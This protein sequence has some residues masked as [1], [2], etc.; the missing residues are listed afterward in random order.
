MCRPIYWQV[1]ASGLS[2]L[3]ELSPF[4]QTWADKETENNRT[5][6]PKLHL[7]GWSREPEV[8]S[9]LLSLVRSSILSRVSL[10][11]SCDFGSFGDGARLQD[12][13]GWILFISLLYM[14][15]FSIT[16]YIYFFVGPGSFISIFHPIR[17]GA[18][19]WVSTE[20][21]E[22]AEFH[23]NPFLSFIQFRQEHSSL[24]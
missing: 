2:R 19:S 21:N 12:D 7:P 9:L 24:E 15:Q 8:H 11:N 5:S 6:P 23:S 14:S 13:I 18:V 10:C 1:N 22:K 20:H 4:N 3:T 17:R 16:A